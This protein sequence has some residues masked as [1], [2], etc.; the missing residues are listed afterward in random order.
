MIEKKIGQGGMAALYQAKR[1]PNV[2]GAGQETIAG[3]SPWIAIKQI[4]P[5]LTED[6]Q[7]VEMFIDEAMIAVHLQ[8]PNIAQVHDLG[9]EAGKHFM[10]MEFVDGCDL[11]KW[12]E[13]CVSESN[14]ELALHII[15][16]VADGLGYAHTA[17]TKSGQTLNVVHRDVSPQNILLSVDGEVKVT[18]FGLAKA[19]K[20]LVNTKVGVV[21]GKLSYMAP[22][23]INGYTDARSDIYALGVIAWEL[24]AQKRLFDSSND[25]ETVRMIE[26]ESPLWLGYFG[27][28]EGLAKVIHRMLEKDI[29]KRQQNMIQ[30][31]EELQGHLA[32][33]DGRTMKRY[34]GS[35][36]RQVLSSSLESNPTSLYPENTVPNA[37]K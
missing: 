36:V 37:R 32:K 35:M 31:Q 16:H 17:T 24:L 34:L 30:V 29:S 7:F 27:I 26:R 6:T 28:H 11:K 23:Q 13:R 1:M 21:K 2:Q 22:E 19:S 4:L 8:H 5:H 9:E 18:D 14:P 12:F 15:S 3:F 10:V 20:R 33:T 25:V